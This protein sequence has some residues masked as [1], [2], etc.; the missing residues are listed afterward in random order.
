MASQKRRNAVRLAL[1]ASLLSV[2]NDL[3]KG[4]I[5]VLVTATRNSNGPTFI[6]LVHLPELDQLFDEL[7]DDFLLFQAKAGYLM[8]NFVRVAACLLG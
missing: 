5:Q 7:V 3:Q 2:K 4:R 1:Y 6:A 8:G